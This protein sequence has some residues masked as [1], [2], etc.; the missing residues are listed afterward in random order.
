MHGNLINTSWQY[1]LFHDVPDDELGSAVAMT[2]TGIASNNSV[3]NT[4]SIALTDS[5]ISLRSPRM[6]VGSKL[7]L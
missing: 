2:H 5:G 3:R 1:E 7:A 4:L 6:Y